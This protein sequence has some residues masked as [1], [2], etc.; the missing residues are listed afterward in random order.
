MY[1]QTTK[2]GFT[3]TASESSEKQWLLRLQVKKHYL[4]E[5]GRAV[6]HEVFSQVKGFVDTFV[7]PWV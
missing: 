3:A 7:E 6:A 4:T 5:V 2:S 1:Q